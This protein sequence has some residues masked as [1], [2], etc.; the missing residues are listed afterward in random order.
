MNSDKTAPAAS[1]IR[2]SRLHPSL[3]GALVMGFGSVIVVGMFLVQ[4]IAM[5]SAQKNTRELLSDN[6]EFAMVSLVRETRRRLAPVA[7]INEYI[8]RLIDTEQIDIDKREQ[9]GELLLA[10]MASTEQVYGMGFLYPDG[11]MLRVRRGRGTLPEGVLSTNGGNRQV[12]ADAK[13]RYQT[14]WGQPH[15]LEIADSAVLTARTP[16]WQG[17]TFKGLL[18]TA[19][20]TQVLSKFIARSAALPLADNRFILYGRDHVLAHQSMVKG[21]YPRDNGIPLPRTD[22]I[23]D[24]VLSL[25]WDKSD[26][27]NLLIDLDPPTNG[28]VNIINGD[29]HIFLYCTGK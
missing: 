3:T 23:D 27:R 20:T 7:K 1:A 10:A 14:Y 2:R 4:G 16:I 28:H 29:S 25:I 11:T 9:F 19:V 17:Q 12:L 22:Q 24:P 6:A 15:W 21:T 8:Q 5:W 18:V 13:K 26:R